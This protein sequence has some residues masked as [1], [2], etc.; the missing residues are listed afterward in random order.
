MSSHQ[1]NTQGGDITPP[2][3]A[4]NGTPATSANTGAPRAVPS[5]KSPLFKILGAII[6]AGAIGT[7][8]V[9]SFASA[10]QSDSLRTSLTIVAPAGAGGGWDTVAREMQQAQRANGIVNNTQVVNMPGAG[11]TI[12]LG[13]IANLEGDP[14]TLMVGGTGQ[15][16]ATIQYD[17]DTTYTDITPLAITVEEYNLVVVPANSPY[18]SLEELMTAWAADPSAVPWSGGGSFDQLVAT[19]LAI[20]AGVDPKDMVYVSSDGGGEVTAA[21]LNG[22]V[23]AAASGFS[24]SIDQVESGRLRALGLVSKER[25][26]GVDIPTTVEQGYDVTLSNWRLIAAPGGLTAEEEVEL[27]DIVLETV[28]TEGWSTAVGRYNWSERVITGDELDV[29]LEEEKERISSLYESLG[30]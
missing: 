4:S 8:T 25:F 28:E 16:A 10:N 11:G 20:A 26:E 27:T 1:D 5:M 13:N 15:L 18:Q 14:S 12:A 17:T 19:E 29:F 21:L 23:H 7:A 22:T 24:D 9:G 2:W 3:S 6:A 30:V